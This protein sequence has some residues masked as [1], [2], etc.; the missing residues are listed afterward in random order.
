[1]GLPAL[2]RPDA[3]VG[4]RRVDEAIEEPL[5]GA[6]QDPAV[7]AQ[8]LR[9]SMLRFLKRVEGLPLETLVQQRYER[10]RRIGTFSSTQRAGLT[11]SA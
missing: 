8:H 1:M 2:L 6:H 7:V 4:A 5:G 9:A 3:G 11:P 10:F